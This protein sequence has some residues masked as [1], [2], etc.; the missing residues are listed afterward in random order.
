MTAHS[1]SKRLIRGI[2]RRLGMRLI[3][4][5]LSYLALRAPKK[6]DS[7]RL[8][9]AFNI[10][11]ILQSWGGGNQWLL[12]FS[13]HLAAQGHRVCFSLQA[14][15]DVVFIVDP[16]P[17][18]QNYC[19]GID[20]I[21]KARELNPK[22]SCVHRINECDLRKGTT[23]V[24]E[25]MARANAVADYTVFVSQWLADYHSARWFDS[26][27]PYAAILNGADPKVFYPDPKKKGIRK[28]MPVRVVTHHWSDNWN[29]GFVEYKE[30]DRAIADGELPGVE[31]WV[32]GRWPKDLVWRAAK[33][34]PACQGVALANLLRQC[35]LYVTA[36]R[37]EPG[38]MHYV[39][40]AQCGLPVIYHVDSGGTVEVVAFYGVAFADMPKLAILEAIQ[41]FQ[42][43]QAK[44]L[45]AMPSGEV[46]CQK[47]MEVL[48]K[49]Q[50]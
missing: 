15:V 29:K 17:T 31:L 32:I 35:D 10:H 14:A 41:K 48:N 22:I 42:E 18:N 6:K 34:F 30:I 12:Q 5:E 16:N 38:A 20:E 4:L 49:V 43:L 26:Q 24:D 37:W 9:V 21:R 7:Q 1:K 40:G 2:K 25:L 28:S 44:C 23:G 33:T 8:C 50:S 3:E 19:F 46:M 11:P 45:S 36:S 47:Y 39:E 13:R 27:R